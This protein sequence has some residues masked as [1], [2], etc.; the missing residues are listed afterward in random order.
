MWTIL[1]KKE[2]TIDTNSDV[3]ISIN[4]LFYFSIISIVN[5]L[6][7]P[8]YIPYEID[9]PLMGLKSMPGLIILNKILVQL[10]DFH[11]FVF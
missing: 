5:R 4:Y 2:T 11:S 7:I 9:A 1:Y 8:Q 10:Q 6:R 3:I